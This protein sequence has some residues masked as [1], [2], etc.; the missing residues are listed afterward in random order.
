MTQEERNVMIIRQNNLRK[1]IDILQIEFEKKQ[2]ALTQISHKLPAEKIFE[3]YEISKEVSC[4]KDIVEN[5]HKF[6]IEKPEENKKLLEELN[7]YPEYK[8]F[9]NKQKSYDEIK[10]K[11]YNELFNYIN[12]IDEDRKIWYK[13]E[14][15]KAMDE[16][17]ERGIML[18]YMQTPDEPILQSNIDTVEKNILDSYSSKNFEKLSNMCADIFKSDLGYN[19]LKH[20]KI[21]DLKEAIK[22][23]RCAAYQSCARTLFS[24]LEN[25]YKNA[26]DIMKQCK[27]AQVNEAVDNNIKK[28]NSHY[29]QKAWKHMNKYYKLLICNTDKMDKKNI[30]RHDLAHGTYI[31][32]ADKDDCTK[33]FLLFISFKELSF[34]LQQRFEIDKEIMIYLYRMSKK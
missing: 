1:E 18:F 6:I 8:E 3:K 24:L 9:L 14:Y 34:V 7:S 21:D 22:C 2:F 23:L 11:Y 5:I 26:S 10:Y 13:N 20:N 28:I 19:E 12:M 25:E 27:N 17:A 30:N 4:T 15:K 32:I 31:H 33:L 16:L 29:Y